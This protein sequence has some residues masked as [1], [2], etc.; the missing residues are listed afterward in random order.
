MLKL[1]PAR[2]QRILAV[3][4]WSRLEH[5]S[6]NLSVDAGVLEALLLYTPVWT[7][8]GTSVRYPP[9]FQ[10]IPLRRGEYYY[11]SAHAHVAA[12]SEGILVRRPKIIAGYP[13]CVEVFAATNLTER[14]SLQLG[15]QVS[16]ELDLARSPLR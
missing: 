4:Q 11:Y 8:P 10:H 13:R 1:N 3:T 6:L 5:G 9:P 14:F 2:E 15:E 7:E 16:V 12:E